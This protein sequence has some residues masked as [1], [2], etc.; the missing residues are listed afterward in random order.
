MGSVLVFLVIMA[1]VFTGGGGGGSGGQPSFPVP[2]G[3]VYGC[4]D[5]EALCL[6]VQPNST[7][8]RDYRGKPRKVTGSRGV[9]ATDQ[10]RCADIGAAVLEEGGHAVDAAVAA[11]LCQGVVNPF[12]SGIGGGHFAMIRLA[13]GST[14]FINAREVAP[15]AA[16]KD[17]YAGLP[18]N[19][20]VYGGLAVAVPLELRGL[21]LAWRRHGRLPWARLVAPAAEI[22]A[23]GF[24]AHPYYVYTVGPYTLRVLQAD[25]LTAEAFLVRDAATG[26]YRAPFVGEL[27]CRRPAL[28]A[29]LN[30]V[31]KY[32]VDW[33][34][35]PERLEALAREVREAGGVMTAQDL[36]DAQPYVTAP[37]S[38]PL[39]GPA[40]YTLVL[41][42]P[43]SSGAVAALA[44]A[45]LGGYPT[46]WADTEPALAA[47]RTVEAF[48][49]AFAVRSA[50]GDP[51][52]PGAANPFVDVG[53]VLGDVADPAFVD[54]LRAAINDS[55]VLPLSAYGGKYNP[56]LSGSPGPAPEDRG[57]SHLAVLDAAGN[58]VSLTTTVNGP[59]GAAVISRSTGIL[60][61]NEMDDFSKPDAPN[62]YNL[63]PSAANYIAPFKRPLSSM[64][65]AFVLGPAPGGGQRLVMVV[66]ASNGPRILTGI[67]QTVLRTLYGKSDPLA[68]VSGGRL[69]SQWLP[70][71]VLYENYTALAAPIVNDPAVVEALRGRGNNMVQYGSQLGD[72]QAILVE[73]QADGSLRATAVADPRKDGAP[74]AARR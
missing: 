51:G 4:T 63:A 27:C 30:A 23:H 40:N 14:E 71:S 61:N 28:A 5:S 69:H 17:L 35:A 3:A 26:R 58:A 2:E 11:A 67:V 21:E 1:A 56:I 34:Y 42:P 41:P 59:F 9:V 45:I 29:T 22:A 25:P 15:G 47:H 49:H 66:G 36:Q 10:S 6:I 70:D 46:P 65:P 33:L 8:D 20:S 37:L 52:P 74:A 57:T 39:P 16:H 55:S 60:L 18:S 73:A 44:L 31:A 72:V 24:A 54:Q 38:F 62:I 68:A 13:N 43:P 53:G 48:K 50:M 64:A 7:A 19:A 12:A 32:G